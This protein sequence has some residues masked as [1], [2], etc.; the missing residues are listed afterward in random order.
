[1]INSLEQQYHQHFPIHLPIFL[2]QSFHLHH[3]FMH[4]ISSMFIICTCKFSSIYFSEKR[5]KKPTSRLFHFCSISNLFTPMLLMKLDN[6]TN[7]KE[8]EEE[9]KPKRIILQSTKADILRY[10]LIL[11]QKKH[12]YKRVLNNQCTRK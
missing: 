5:E 6:K 8:D 3:L 10:F 1:M 4:P 11:T 2:V 9:K 12:I 7:N